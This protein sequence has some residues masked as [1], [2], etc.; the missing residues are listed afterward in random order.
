VSHDVVNASVQGSW[1]GAMRTPGDTSTLGDGQGVY[2]VHLLLLRTGRILMFSGGWEGNDLLHRSSSFDPVTWSPAAPTTGVIG[3]WFLPQFDDDP[4][5]NPPPPTG[6][7]DPDIDLFCCHHVQ[8]EDGRILVVGGDGISSHNNDAIHF[9]DPGLERWSRIPQ[10]MV[11][12][13]WYPTAVALPDGSVVTFSGDSATVGLVADTELMS[14]PGYAPRVL[15]GGRRQIGGVDNAQRSFPGMFLVP[16]GRLFYVPTA[17]SYDGGTTAQVEAQLGNTMSFRVTD[18]NATPPVGVWTDHGVRPA[19]MMRQEG[20]AVLLAPAQAGRIALIGG[21]RGQTQ[22][23][24]NTIEILETQ[25]P[26]P[27]WVPG[28]Q[29]HVTR[30]N[31]NAVLLP[32]GKVLIVGGTG[33]YKWDG[34]GATDLR[35][36][37]AELWDPSVPYDAANPTAA[38]T[39]TGEMHRS[40]QYHSGAVLLPD[41]R[42]LVSGGEDNQGPTAAGLG[43]QPGEKV[44]SSQRTMEFYEPPYMH[45]GPRPVITSIGETG[46]VDDEIHY[47]GSFTIVTPATD[48]AMVV[49]MRPGAATHHTDTE[50]RHV[51]LVFWPVAAGYRARVVGDPTIAPPGYYMVWILDSQG[52]PCVRAP[53]VRLSGRFCEVVSDR[54]AFSIHEVQSQAV[55]GVSVIEHAC[56]VIVNGYRPNQL[57]ITTTTPSQTQ[58]DAWAPA[59]AFTDAS[60]GAS[61]VGLSAQPS[62]MLLEVN[63]LGIRQRVTFEYAVRFTGTAMFPTAVTGNERRAVRLETTISGQ[64]C[65]AAIALFL[66]PNPYMLDGPTSW[67]SDDLR[68]FQIQPSGAQSGIPLAAGTSPQAYLQTF[69]A[70]CDAAADSAGHPFRLITTNQQGSALELSSQLNGS[71]VYN[72]A[73]ARVRYR[74]VSTTAPDVRMFFRAFTTAATSMEYRAETYPWSP[75]TNLPGVGANATDVLSIPFFS[76]PRGS[77]ATTG[78][79]QNV[80]T[81]PASGAGGETLRYFG[82]WLDINDTTPVI[83]DPA[84]GI[85]KS[86]QAL[87]RGQHQCLI[88]EIRFG[89][90]P[91]PTGAT[92]A[93]NENLS[94]R[95]LAIL[96]SDNPGPIDAHTVTHTLQL[97]TTFGEA[98]GDDTPPMVAAMLAL[99]RDTGGR[100][101]IVDDRQALPLDGDVDELM[102]IWGDLPEDA[103]VTLFLP[104]VD[105][106]AIVAA[107]G[108]RQGPHRVE[109]VDE[110]TVRCLVGEVT[111]VPLPA[112]RPTDVAGLLT[113]VMPQTVR[114]AETYRVLVRQRSR[115]LGRITGTFEVFVRV[116]DADR[117][118][119]REAR[120]LAV[121]KSI[122]A[123]IRP[124]S[125]WFAVFAR[126][127]EIVSERVRGAG[128]LPELIGPSP[129]GHVPP[130]AVPG[131]VTTRDCCEEVS[132]GIRTWLLLFLFAIVLLFAIVILIILLV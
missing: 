71:P 132:R 110:H 75:A 13:R 39:V 65:N 28:G 33:G 15:L 60:T 104:V 36:F 32:D 51:P 95:N 112:A 53:F 108:L 56:Y 20:T 72:F 64:T 43:P 44:G 17:F 85:V 62:A 25:G 16:G 106:D 48:V 94:Q 24:G 99:P 90:D 2:P 1:S 92:P 9:Y 12:G 115:A 116:S 23:P 84:D 74:A 55:G 118:V 98:R 31:V 73:I 93:A 30:A 49:L 70:A 83:T 34:F 10:E 57:G 22:A 61:V 107:A 63:D 117:I 29:M 14:P 8:V 41:G 103:E 111:Y 78:D 27:Q 127:L 54:S 76:A 91:I 105:A 21:G 124:N 4:I 3:R 96:E 26:A 109:K 45:N 46:G 11:A 7:D 52:R 47:G 80:K 58:L 119:V 114:T 50:Q 89:P 5:A 113:I 121:L 38:L 68:V 67:L 125:A 59:V 37:A 86:I 122:A 101:A 6:T 77:V 102:L 129:A 131:V 82:A 128:G 88:A 35:R 66:Q 19:D 100:A 87:I 126:Y 81:L 120:L 123:G 97:R 79:T 18:P 40:R 130:A 42:V 69:L